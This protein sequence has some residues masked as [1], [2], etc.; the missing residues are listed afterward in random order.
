M[1][2][3]KQV[4]GR[5]TGIGDLSNFV[6][7]VCIPVTA[8]TSLSEVNNVGWLQLLVKEGKQRQKRTSMKFMK[9]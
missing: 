7:V 5:L 1:I 2:A 8:L 3:I 6:R 4:G 9:A